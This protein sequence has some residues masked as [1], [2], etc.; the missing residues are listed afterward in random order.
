MFYGLAAGKIDTG[1]LRIDLVAAAL[2][3]LN[4]RAHRGELEASMISAAA[5]PYLRKRYLLARCGVRFAGKHG[6]VLAAP[7]PIP[8]GT[9]PNL[10]IA[11]GDATSSGMVALQISQ[12]GAK[13]RLL[14]ADK[15]TQ[16]IKMGLADCALL[17]HVNRAAFAQSGLC[18][19]A[20]LAAGWAQKTGGL[21]LPLT[22]LVIR[23]DL[24]EE[25]RVQIE[26]VLRASIRFGLAHRSEAARFAADRLHPSEACLP[27]TE[28]GA[29][30]VCVSQET[31]E[32]G[33]PHRAALE[34]FLRRGHDADVIPNALPLEF[35][36]DEV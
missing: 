22:C 34:E 23:S 21:P 16:A 10:T 4:D 35:V 5:Y 8:E 27:E 31:L 15:L 25:T 17:T 13:T 28:I 29:L 24:S 3:A 9:I 18:C 7:Q 12:P 33:A 26:D 2:P 14:P 32:L 11:V 6:P 36:G 1:D 30:G 20:D 19:V